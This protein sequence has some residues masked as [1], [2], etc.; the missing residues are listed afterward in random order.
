MLVGVVRLRSFCDTTSRRRDNN[1][2]QRVSD[3][4]RR[5]DCLAL[6]AAAAAVV[7]RFVRLHRSPG[8]VWHGAR[9]YVPLDTK[10]VISETFF[11]AN[12]LTRY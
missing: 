2:I 11:P 3:C 12:L 6:A 4:L 8:R 10:Q 1:Q 5:P 9:S 7:G